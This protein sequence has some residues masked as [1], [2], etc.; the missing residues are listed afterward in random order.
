VS[1]PIWLISL[2]LF[3]GAVWFLGQWPPLGLQFR[4]T[5][6]AFAVLGLGATSAGAISTAHLLCYTPV[7]I[8]GGYFCRLRPLFDLNRRIDEIA[9]GDFFNAEDLRQRIEGAVREYNEKV[10]EDQRFQ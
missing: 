5:C 2:L 10:D 1:S 4:I 3:A 8:L 7:A 6:L 9:K